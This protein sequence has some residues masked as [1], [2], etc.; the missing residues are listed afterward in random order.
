MAN[1]GNDLPLKLYRKLLME[2]YLQNCKD[3]D[4]IKDFLIKNH[5][6]ILQTEDRYI[7]PKTR[8]NILTEKYIKMMAEKP[9]RNPKRRIPLKN[10]MSSG[11]IVI[12]ENKKKE[13]IKMNP[14]VRTNQDSTKSYEISKHM[15]TFKSKDNLKNFYLDNFNSVKENNLARS[16]TNVSS[17]F[18]N[19]LYYSFYRKDIFVDRKQERRIRRNVEAYRDCIGNMFEEHGKITRVPKIT[20]KPGNSNFKVLAEEAKNNLSDRYYYENNKNQW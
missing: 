16:K 1:H 12:A 11:L 2:S 9:K 17:N 6:P 20:D 15:R 8:G 14:K 10:S 7:P 4:K 13:G 5:D 3:G 18:F 19:I